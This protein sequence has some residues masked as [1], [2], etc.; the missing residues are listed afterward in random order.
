M[1]KKDVQKRMLKK[2]VKKI[3]KKQGCLKNMQKKDVQK[4]ML[5]KDAKKDVQKKMLKNKVNQ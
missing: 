2:Y 5:K 1:R 3:C 4:R